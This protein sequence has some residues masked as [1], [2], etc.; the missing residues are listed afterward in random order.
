MD[1][2]AEMR[3][4]VCWAA[5][6]LA[7]A[8]LPQPG[9]AQID[10]QRDDRVQVSSDAPPVDLW[11]DQ[12]S[13]DR[14][15]RMRPH[16]TTEPGA[17]LVVLRVNTEGSLSILYPE[18]P[19]DLRPYVLGSFSGDA[20]PY[21]GSQA[22]YLN[23]S[24]GNGFVFAVATYDRFDFSA[25]TRGMT[26]R[27]DRIAQFRRIVDPFETVRQF[28][29]EVLPQSADYS[30]DYEHYEVYS[31]GLRNRSNMDVYRS[32][33]YWGIEEYYSSCLNAFGY[34]MDYYC[35]PYRG[36][37]YGP[38]IIASNPRPP[39]PGNPVNPRGKRIKPPES[40]G[41]EPVVPKSPVTPVEGTT[42]ANTRA[43]NAER[44]NDR[45]LR[46]KALP[47]Q[48]SENQ[49]GQRSSNP[50]FG[51]PRTS[52]P[53]P[54]ARRMPVPERREPV[55]YRSMPAREHRSEPPPQRQ[56]P[57]AR[58]QQRIETRAP[59]GTQA[60]REHHAERAR[61]KEKN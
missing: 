33:G 15:A 9:S 31:R 14:G 24:G 30:L 29:D 18:R 25:Y 40:V 13:F 44:E 19:H 35:R 38:I 7:S 39:R 37:Y 53:V 43:E 11:L 20:V 59:V 57:A 6:A 54:E 41:H 3:G 22:F 12:I 50:R 47:R 23:E 48:E 28:L 36:R 5:V 1:V 42:A 26:W 8:S 52:A 2:E 34:R 4:F 49:P 27:F 56:Q 58:E 16:V 51:N 46:A 60:P 55:I 32:V 61:S 21:R 10:V 45:R 17:Y